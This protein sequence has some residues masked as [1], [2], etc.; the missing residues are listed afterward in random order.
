MRQVVSTVSILALVALAGVLLAGA[1]LADQGDSPA[2][3]APS[4]SGAKAKN[5]ARQP[6]AVTPEREAAVLNFVERN[7]AELS[8]LLAHLKSDQPKQF[9]QAIKEIYRVTERLANVQERDV[10]LYELEV[11]LWTAQ[12]RVQLLAAR[13]K[14]GDSD[15][16]KK[17]L[18]EA[19]ARQIEARLD[20]LKHQKQQASERLIKMGSDINQL[21]ANKEQAIERQLE[22]LARGAAVKNVTKAAGIK[23]GAKSGKRAGKEAAKPVAE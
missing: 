11:K 17:E 10:L 2:S 20:V 13:L 9:E 23:P 5:K 6:L 8:E 22:M 18:R 12:S 19:L 7:H 3:R 21:E 14:M 4:P 15:T 16:I 1:L